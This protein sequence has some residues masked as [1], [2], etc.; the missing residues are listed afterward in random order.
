ML[1]RLHFAPLPSAEPAV[2][3]HDDRG[4]LHLIINTSVPIRRRLAAV[5]VIRAALARRRLGG[6]ILPLLLLTPPDPAAA[7]HP[8]D[9]PL[10]APPCPAAVVAIQDRRT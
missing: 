1:A 5:R 9:V 8:K 10:A 4:H 7:P 3:W 6:L 2:A